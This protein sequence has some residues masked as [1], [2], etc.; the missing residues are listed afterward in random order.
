MT[1]DQGIEQFSRLIA[2]LQ[3]PADPDAVFAEWFPAFAGLHVDDVADGVTRLLRGKTDRWWPTIGELRGCIASVQAGRTSASDACPK[4]HG[5]RWVEARPYRA[6]GEHVYRGV[7]RCPACGVPAP[8][9]EGQSR[10]TPFTDA[11]LAAWRHARR[12]VAAIETRAEFLAAVEALAGRKV[13][14]HLRL[15]TKERD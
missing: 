12:P 3:P 4:C 15:V 11:Q 7:T 8:R 5:S 2:N 13:A 9:L 1:R 10:Q 6:N 14:A